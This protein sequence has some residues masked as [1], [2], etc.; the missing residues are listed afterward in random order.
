M[1][2]LQKL[3][4]LLN[5]ILRLLIYPI[6]VFLFCIVVLIEKVILIRVGN[7]KNTWVGTWLIT[8]EIYLLEK[9]LFKIKSIDIF[10]LDKFISNSFVFSKTK[11]K[12]IVIPHYFEDLLIIVRYFA[13]KH[14]YFKRFL[15]HR[16]T[17]V[18]DINLL[19]DNTPTE[20]SLS[21]KEIKEGHKILSDNT[22][23]NNKGIVLLCVRNENYLTNKFSKSNWDH[24]KYRNYKINDF[25]LASEYL[26]SEGYLVLRMGNLN[27]NKIESNHKNIIDYSFSNWR[28]DFMDFFLGYICSFCISTSTGMDTFARI[29][30]KPM[31][32]INNPINNIYYFHDNWTYIFGLFQNKK[33]KK[34]LTLD[35]IFKNKLD[36][37]TT[38]RNIYKS[39]E[40]D[41]IKNNPDQIKNLCK[42]VKEKYEKNFNFLEYNND[43]EEKFW[44]TFF[45]Y[46][47][48]RVDKP[49][50]KNR[51]STSFLKENKDILG[52]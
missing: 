34:Y 48:K 14:D 42:E 23:K 28:S 18:F 45:N 4:T 11:E 20:L 37:I 52:L 50:I 35:E 12:I 38:L 29:H 1:F 9:K 21:D 8:N 13:N 49:K 16:E 47:E 25:V 26:A 5:I 27:Y 32:L 30:R 41:L 51:I 33:T 43:Y 39:E 19:M 24:L 22:D 31:G 40:Y 10:I 3:K 6:N 44:K 7:Q 2:F 36:K 15:A 46:N 17:Q